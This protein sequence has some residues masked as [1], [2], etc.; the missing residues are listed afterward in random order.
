MP[1][2]HA[3]VR[4]GQNVGIRVTPHKYA[5]RKYKVAKRK[6]DRPTEVDLEEIES[7]IKQGY[8]LRMSN[9]REKHPPGLFMPDSIYCWK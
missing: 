2:L 1:L 6:E 8:G 5:N 4:R 9:K 3:I 7:F